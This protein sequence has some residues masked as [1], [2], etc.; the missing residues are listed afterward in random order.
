MTLADDT[1]T[2]TL[3]LV[4]L[5]ACL[6]RSHLYL[7]SSSSCSSLNPAARLVSRVGV[8]ADTSTSNAT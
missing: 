6:H 3:T 4:S 2:L 1:L 8:R 5:T 7:L